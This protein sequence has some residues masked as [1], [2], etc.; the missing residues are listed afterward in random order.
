MTPDEWTP[1]FRLAVAARIARRLR[2]LLG[3]TGFNWATAFQWTCDILSVAEGDRQLLNYVPRRN[4]IESALGCSLEKVREELERPGRVTVCT[5]P[6]AAQF[7][8][9]AHRTVGD[10]A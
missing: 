1:D 6:T 8:P 4:D 10:M 5:E 9:G 2:D 3:K 7:N